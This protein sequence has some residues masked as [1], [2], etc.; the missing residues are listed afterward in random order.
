[1]ETVYGPPRSCQSVE[2]IG[3]FASCSFPVDGGGTVTVRYRGPDGGYASNSPDDIVH[4]IRWYEQVSGW[5]TTAG[6]NT[7]IAADDPQD[8]I[9]AYPDA[10]VTG[11]GFGGVYSV[12]DH[13]QGIEVIWAPDFYRG[14]THVNMAI[15][16]PR[17]AP[18]PAEKL[19]R[20][21]DIELASKKV[22]GKRL[23]TALV[24]VRNE[25]DVAAKGATVLATW[26][27]PDS[28]TQPAMDI[29]SMSGY[30]YF[31]IRPTRRGTYTLRIDDV[32]LS[33]H[34][35]DPDNSVLEDSIAVK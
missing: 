20:V 5:M 3:D 4:N 21:I 29:T 19:T 30:A 26:G 7:S 32:I 15:F 11:N 1:V 33:E 2:S 28:S 34:R 14:T 22:K 9:D 31:E 17:P 23:I 27:Y 13:E 8:V 18:I 12:V 10:E 16:Y 35:F 24:Q 6:I 25:K